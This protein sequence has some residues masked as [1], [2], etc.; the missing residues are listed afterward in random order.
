MAIKSANKIH[1]KSHP[2]LH[3][4]FFKQCSLSER[5]A[6]SRERPRILLRILNLVLQV[7]TII[8]VELCTLSTL[9][10]SRYQLVLDISRLGRLDT[11]PSSDAE[12]G[13]YRVVLGMAR[14]NRIDLYV[15]A[16]ASK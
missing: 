13:Q 8:V 2:L 12:D 10:Y 4:I 16:L 3:S 1:N 15:R 6:S 5:A 7:C 9:W 11:L 14:D